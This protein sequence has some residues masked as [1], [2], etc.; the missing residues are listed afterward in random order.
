MLDNCSNNEID[1][2]DHHLNLLGQSKEEIK[3]ELNH[4]TRFNQALITIEASENA[5]IHVNDR[6]RMIKREEKV[7]KF[8]FKQEN[9]L[10][11]LPYRPINLYEYLEREMT[12]VN[13]CWSIDKLFFCEKTSWTMLGIWRCPMAYQKPM[14]ALFH[15]ESIKEDLINHSIFS[16]QSKIK[17][18]NTATAIS[19]TT[20]DT[21][22]ALLI[23]KIK[24]LLD[25]ICTT[26]KKF[27]SK[28]KFKKDESGFFLQHHHY[29]P[30]LLDR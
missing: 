1:G 15:D 14:R 2:F 17:I 10:I 6:I 20:Q 18:Q 26:F 9:H 27:K 16:I 24:K 29:L 12:A 8:G 4:S 22:R 11:D 13:I 28:K 23:A 19:Q 30:F 25:R 5:Q 21:L 7:L 3:I